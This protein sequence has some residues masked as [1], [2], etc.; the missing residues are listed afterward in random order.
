M[1][2]AVFVPFWSKG[3]DSFLKDPTNADVSILEADKLQQVVVVLQAPELK[4]D[5]LTYTSQGA[6]GRDASQ[7]RRCVRI[8]RHHRHAVGMLVSM[9]R[10]AARQHRRAVLR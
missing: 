6:A 10:C 2:T 4:G 9:R 5:T 8:H 7:G 3:K 1:G